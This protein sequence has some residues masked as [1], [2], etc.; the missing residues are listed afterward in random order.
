MLLSEQM[1][2]EAAEEA[3]RA[4]AQLLATMSH[5]LRTPL[6]TIIGFWD[7]LDGGVGGPLTEGRWHR[8]VILSTRRCTV[9]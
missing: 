1:A 2:R 4:K 5:E 3:N 9:R 8:R 7:L 6:N